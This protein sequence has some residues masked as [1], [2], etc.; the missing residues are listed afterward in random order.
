MFSRWL[1]QHRAEPTC[2]FRKVFLPRKDAV[3]G[4]VNALEQAKVVAFIKPSCPTDG[5]SETLLRDPKEAKEVVQFAR[6]QIFRRTNDCLLAVLDPFTNRFPFRI[7]LQ[8]DSR[9]QPATSSI[10]ARIAVRISLTTFLASPKSTVTSR[11]RTG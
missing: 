3:Y 10:Y 9:R 4:R 5:L 7:E 2:V 8:F 1:D 11:L 6:L